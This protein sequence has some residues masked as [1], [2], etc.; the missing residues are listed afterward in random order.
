MNDEH[1]MIAADD[2]LL[3]ALARGER[4][5][6]ADEVS[7]MLAAW[8]ADVHPDVDT[9]VA[10]EVAAEPEEAPSAP[11]IPLRRV[12]P[13]RRLAVAA[14]AAL[15][16]GGGLAVVAAAGAKPGSP[17]WPITRVVYPERADVAA[18]Q[19]A[20]DRARAAATGGR[21]DEARRLVA[22]ADS[23]IGRVRSAPDAQRLRTELDEVRR[24]L[25]ALTPVPPGGTV[26]TPA[27]PGL[28][29]APNPGTG[30]TA[31][32]GGQGGPGGQQ[33]SPGGGIVPSLPVPSVPVPTLPLPTLPH[34]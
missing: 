9:D 34:L 19:D 6:G 16:L 1:S 18:A 20:V 2:L 25:T 26:T 23:L 22:E 30:G 3:D 24:M 8:R 28:T 13:L 10:A 11:V 17:L 12:R 21:Y 31:P 14:A 4:P 7:A 33:T 15:V 27:P 32:G 29:P 5:E